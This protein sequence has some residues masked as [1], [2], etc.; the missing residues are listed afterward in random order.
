MKRR[1]AMDNKGMSLVELLVVV[2]II[3]VLAGAVG[4]GIGMVSGKP[5]EQCA[6]KMQIALENNRNTSMGK[7]NVTISFYKDAEGRIMAEEIENQGLANQSTKTTMLGEAG[8]S[9]KYELDGVEQELGT[10][11]LTLSFD[12]SN[13]SL[14]PY[15]EVSGVKKYITK[16]VISKAST[17]RELNI[18]PLTGKVSV[19]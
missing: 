17:V 4:Y 9:V 6:K 5:A 10:S 3:A 7:M 13:G 11:K 15:S 12:R 8:V 2:A 16:F 19:K 1:N 18:V 14:N